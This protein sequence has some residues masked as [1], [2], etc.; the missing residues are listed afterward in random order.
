MD[1]RIQQ[2]RYRLTSAGVDQNKIDD[3]VA[4]VVDRAKAKLTQSL[5]AGV[6]LATQEAE[7]LKAYDFLADISVRSSHDGFQI[8]SDGNS[9]YST[10]PFP[11]LDRLLAKGKTAKDGSTYRVIPIGSGSQPKNIM[12]KDVSSGIAAAS[13]VKTTS[14][15][16]DI[17]NNMAAAFGASA[18]P[19]SRT[20]EGKPRGE[21]AFRVASSKQDASSSWVIPAR[22]K[23][24]SPA[25][26]TINAMMSGEMSN[27]LDG[28]IAEIEGEIQD[29][30]RDA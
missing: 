5:E 10:P 8:T 9:D 20:I 26:N 29:V 12:T 22:N 16:T 17:A 7:K 23:D 2:L 13:N 6:S 24:M 11:M 21:V 1:Q 28:A 19:V 27:A 4:S 3:I 30:L 18:R 25:L 15:M 14:S